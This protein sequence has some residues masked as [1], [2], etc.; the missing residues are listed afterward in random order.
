MTGLTDA[1]RS[2]FKVMKVD[3]ILSNLFTRLHKTWLKYKHEYS[4]YK[5]KYPVHVFDINTKY[6]FCI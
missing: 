5:Y 2:D 1:A 6:L 4:N 3:F